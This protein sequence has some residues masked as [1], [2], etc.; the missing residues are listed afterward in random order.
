MS[1]N[2]KP[3]PETEVDVNSVLA[4]AATKGSL[5]DAKFTAL[6][7]LM[8]AREARLAEK[9]KLLDE[10][11]AA[12]DEERK[13]ESERY[14]IAIIENQKNCTHLKGGKGRSRAQQRDP[15]VYG[16]TFTDGKVHIKCTLCK[17]KWMPKDTDEYLDRNGSKIPNWTGIGWAKALAM[18]EDSSNRPSSSERFRAGTSEQFVSDTAHKVAQTA[19]LQL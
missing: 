11:I 10:Q 19:N 2:Q 9:E 3:V 7:S 6:L 18:A 5:S 1:Q 4:E 13:R 12:R 17:A 16:H 14:T 15:A 8:M